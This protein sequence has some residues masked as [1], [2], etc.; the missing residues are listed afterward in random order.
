[1]TEPLMAIRYDLSFFRRRSLWWLRR[2]VRRRCS[3]SWSENFSEL[4]F[5]KIHLF[6]PA[7][8]PA[9][10]NSKAMRAKCDNALVG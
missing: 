3:R 2:W 6:T 7:L 10:V 9:F 5:I 8:P 1:L 4:G